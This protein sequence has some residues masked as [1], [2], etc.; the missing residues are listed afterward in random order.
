MT[1]G[2]QDTVQLFL[3]ENLPQAGLDV[4]FDFSGRYGIDR[5]QLFEGSIPVE[6]LAVG[7]KSQQ[8]LGLQS[9]AG[10]LQRE[11]HQF[12]DGHSGLQDRIDIVVVPKVAPAQHHFH[13]HGT[14][15]FQVRQPDV[16]QELHRFADGGVFGTGI[17]GELHAGH[18]VFHMVDVQQVLLLDIAD[19]G[20]FLLDAIP[21][22]LHPFRLGGPPLHEVEV[23]ALAGR[24]L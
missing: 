9:V 19:S 23:F 8:V 10:I 18:P 24:C 12:I 4:F 14:D 21:F 7:Q 1:E 15:G 22:H 17:E 20:Q 3:D 2:R 11:V 5:F 16:V 6:T 13:F